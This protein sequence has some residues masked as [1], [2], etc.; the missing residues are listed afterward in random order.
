[1]QFLDTITS[2]AVTILFI[3]LPLLGLAQPK[4]N[5]PYSRFGIGDIQDPNFFFS[6]QMG[7]LG[8]S[9]HSPYDIN[10]V[11]PASLS[12]LRTASFDV[13]V[14]A[15]YSALNER[16]GPTTNV[17]SGNL[18]YISLAFP[19]RNA[20]NDLLDRKERDIAFG[21]GFTLK[22]FSTVGYNISSRSI[23]N[24][25]GEV[26]SNFQGTG[27]T[28]DVAWSNSVRYKN[29][30]LGVNLGYLFGQTVNQSFINFLD[31]PFAESA[32][33][34]E[35]LSFSGF[36]YRAGLMYTIPLNDTKVEVG[37]KPISAR[38][39]TIG[40]HA[41]SKT[42][43]DLEN[44][45]FEG[46]GTAEFGGQLRNA[47]NTDTTLISS[48]LPS[49]LGLGLTY[50]SGDKFAIGVNYTAT[51]WSDFDSNV[52]NG[53][54]NDSQKLSFGGYV[55]PNY[56]S[57][58]SFFSRVFYRFGAFY[59]KLPT[60]I[61]VNQGQDIE[62]IGLTFGF[63][64]PFFYQ[65]KISHANLGITLGMRGRNTVIEERYARLT[66]SFTYNDDEWFLKRK[67]N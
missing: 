27:G 57:V 14:S 12:Y 24:D 50:S 60:Q 55:R 36:M 15:R 17:W 10:T 33:I 47:L 35:K 9:F 7:G 8:A 67:Y 23:I 40:L 56:T 48:S 32:L 38:K 44:I 63:G 25:V 16:N 39:L 3:L 59:H 2:K 64:L 51:Q 6:Q 21:M 53:I 46:T 37:Q 62:D 43:V 11:N 1:M 34:E 5:S 54:L 19:L 42:A 18:S 52:V 65:R 30:S 41:N 28:F 26:D 66:F 45:A 20:L 29:L 61:D 22:P 31:I 4:D 49:E 13:G 58:G